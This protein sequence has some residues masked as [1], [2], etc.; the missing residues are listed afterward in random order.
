MQVMSSCNPFF[1]YVCIVASEIV[2]KTL[3]EK[4]HQMGLKLIEIVS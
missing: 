1:V 3:S 4:V 2:I